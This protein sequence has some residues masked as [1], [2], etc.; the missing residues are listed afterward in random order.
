MLAKQNYLNSIWCGL[1][2]GDLFAGIIAESVLNN[3][4]E[5]EKGGV[6][7][8]IDEFIQC[9]KNP[10]QCKPV[11]PIKMCNEILALREIPIVLKKK[12]YFLTGKDNMV[13]S[14]TYNR[15][16]S[17]L[18]RNH[19]DREVRLLANSNGEVRHPNQDGLLEKIIT[20]AVESNISWELFHSHVF[21]EL[22]KVKGFCYT[23]TFKYRIKNVKFIK[24]GES[25]HLLFYSLF[26]LDIRTF[27]RMLKTCNE[28][29]S[30]IRDSDGNTLIHIAACFG[31][32]EYVKA[33]MD[34]ASATG[35]LAELINSRNQDGTNP[36]GMLF[37]NTR[38][39]P[40]RM[41]VKVAQLFI[42]EPSF[43]IN[44]YLNNAKGMDFGSENFLKKIG[45]LTCLHVAL[46]RGLESVLE[47]LQQRNNSLSVSAHSN[48]FV[49]MTF[50]SL[51]PDHHMNSPNKFIPSRCSK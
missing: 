15:Y 13:D 14:Q 51:N 31:R 38:H 4:K 19:P 2:S 23:Y 43:Q 29:L 22:M 8:I 9:V 35:E 27:Q 16:L 39:Y 33:I 46:K 25:D 37:L 6:I 1:D 45:G 36:L 44:S 34:K 24:I 17:L 28:S 12:A 49:N 11:D 47:L 32:H 10:T 26:N 21:E 40:M 41:I 7:A 42:R 30:T 20:K 18:P 5:L 48:D 3:L 50:P